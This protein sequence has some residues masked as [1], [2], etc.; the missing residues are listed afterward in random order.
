MHNYFLF[1][2]SNYFCGTATELSIKIY[3]LS[4]K[5]IASA[6]ISKKLVC[7]HGQFCDLGYRLN[8][9]RTHEKKLIEIDQLCVDVSTDLIG[10]PTIVF[11]D[12]SNAKENKINN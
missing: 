3:K 1:S 5:E 7:F 10:E 2:G 6:V 11:G 4:E 8:F 9:K 12:A